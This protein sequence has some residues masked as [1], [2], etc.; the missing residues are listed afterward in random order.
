MNILQSSPVARASAAAALSFAFLAGSALANGGGTTTASSFNLPNSTPQFEIGVA[1]NRAFVNGAPTAFVGN[2]SLYNSGFYSWLIN[3]GVEATI[4]FETPLSAF[5]VFAR[6]EDSGVQGSVRLLDA[7][8]GLI[9]EF[10]PNNSGFEQFV[11]P[12][13]GAQIAQLVATNTGTAGRIALDDM[14]YCNDLPAPSVGSPFCDPAVVNS[15]GTSATTSATGSTFLAANQLTL[16]AESLPFNSTGFFLVS[17]EQAFVAQPG[18]S[19]GNLCLGASLGRYVGP[20][21]VMNSGATGTISLPVDLTNI[22]APTGPISAVPGDTFFF[23]GWYRDSVGGAS[24]S[25][26]TSGAS[27]TIR[28]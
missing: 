14:V 7:N 6:G 5:S 15:G 17:P 1:P 16:T 20:G 27:L 28:A 3:P 11:V 22:P 4:T 21:Q 18:G 9:V 19:Q 10:T 25:N 8:G 12:A 13:G 26:F 23:Q 2:F 24:T